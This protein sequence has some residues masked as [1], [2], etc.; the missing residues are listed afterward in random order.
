MEA[1]L[2]EVEGLTV[3][4]VDAQSAAVLLDRVSLRVDRGQALAVVGESGGGKTLLGLALLRL[5]PAG[6]A[7]V[8]AGTVRFRGQ[9]LLSLD[10]EALRALRGRELAM[11]AQDP[12]TALN[13]ILPLGKQITEVLVQRRGGAPPAAAERALQL[14]VALGVPH[15]EATLRRLPSQVSKGMAQRVLLAI[16]LAGEPSLLIADEPTASLDADHQRQAFA[17]LAE[18]RRQR[19]MALVFIAHELNTVREYAD[20]VLVLHAGQAV[21]WAS[22]ADLLANPQHPYTQELL[23]AERRLHADLGVPAEGLALAR[24]ERLGSP[25][26]WPSGCRYRT[27]CPRATPECG[28]EP[29]PVSPVAEGHRVACYHPGRPA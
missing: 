20:A 8:E 11:V 1:A 7:R 29:P 17:V 4:L 19:G 28:Q 3:D 12:L 18:A 5:L 22:A 24:A 16:A 13:P 14:L 2:L 26:T 6:R 23:G 10:P 9:D 15:A 21:E 25:A 27:R